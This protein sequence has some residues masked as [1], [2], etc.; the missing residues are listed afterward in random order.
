M[1]KSSNSFSEKNNLIYIIIF[2][3][4]MIVYGNTFTHSFAYDDF[5]VITGN[6][7]TQKGFNG[8]ID[9]L[10]HD[11]FYGFTGKENLFEGGRY[12][13]LSLITF[14]IEYGLWGENPQMNHIINIL[15]FALSMMVLYRLLQMLFKTNS[16]LNVKAK[17]MSIPFVIVALFIVHPIHTEVLANI[18]G[19]DEILVLLF[20]LLAFVY[21][22]KN[23][24]EKKLKY[25]LLTAL[26][27][28]LGLLS[29]ENAIV[30]VLL[31]PLGIWVFS[32]DVKIKK[33]I[34]ATLVVASIVFLIIRQSV[35]GAVQ[36]ES[37]Q[38]DNIINNAFMH[39]DGW[40]EIYGTIFYTWGKYLYLLF[41]PHPLTI[42]YYPFHID[43]VDIF[44][45]KS[46]V[47]LLIFIIAGVVSV[48]GVIKKRKWAYGLVFFFVSFSLV[49]NFLFIVGPFMGE[50]LVFIPSL[51]FILFIVVLFYTY[52]PK[53]T[54]NKI[55]SN[56]VMAFFAIACIAY[57]AKTIDR[58]FDWKDN[59]TLYTTDVHTSPKSAIINQ[60]A[61]QELLNRSN[62][63][64]PNRKYAKL[65]QNQL[66]LAQK[67]ISYAV[68]VNKTNTGLL[69]LGNVLFEKAQ[70]ENAIRQ[71][72]E[73]LSRDP[74]HK[75]AFNNALATC[76]NLQNPQLKMDVY[77][78][79]ISIK[80]SFEANYE[81][82]KLWAMSFNQ[83]DSAIYY[84]NK[85]IEIEND[86]FEAYGGLGLAY[87]MKG[88]LN[89]SLEFMLKSLEM[90]PSDPNT[91]IN[92][93]ITYKNLGDEIK[94]QEYFNKAEQLK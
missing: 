18:K 44:S 6:T 87:A 73:V 19:R 74:Q 7:F 57:A 47:P 3:L 39:A 60:S 4:T 52:L 37:S 36:V 64:K 31:I 41:I 15:L 28:F 11:S 86:H 34:P 45:L 68:K 79:L 50:R 54:S 75:L 22:F 17:L 16:D 62:E 59:F 1:K 33:F 90:N 67:Y 5:S 26:F 29:K 9:H 65:R 72:S 85:A 61:G 43:Y 53:W 30:F 71:Y 42:D 78:N 55:K 63:L 77:E 48:W 10:T 35:L 56:S 93:G 81:L 91:L 38:A 83:P 32:E 66:D 40:R 92:I 14:S 82:G 70:Y 24:Q 46:L 21:A 8:I 76:R 2:L 89:K 94:A 49:S 58:N 23:T 80:S 25:S 20:S 12:R 69:L 84:I 13:P 88:E 51:G 27:I